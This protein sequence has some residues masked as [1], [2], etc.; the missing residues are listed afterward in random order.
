MLEKC[1]L[2]DYIV[3]KYHR[4]CL[5]YAISFFATNKKNVTKSKTI[6]GNS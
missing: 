1:W 2:K 3:C 4:K 6:D 5:V